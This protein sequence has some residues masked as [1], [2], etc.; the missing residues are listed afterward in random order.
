MSAEV[1]HGAK[2]LVTFLV[3]YFGKSTNVFDQQ[4]DVGFL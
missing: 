4:P 2:A 3:P 1:W